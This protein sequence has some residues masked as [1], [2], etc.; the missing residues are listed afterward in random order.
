VCRGLDKIRSVIV[1]YLKD[2]VFIEPT[3][4]T[5]LYSFRMVKSQTITKQLTKFNKIL[6]DLVNIEVII[7]VKDKTLLLLSALHKAKLM[8]QE[9]GGGRKRMFV[10][11]RKFTKVGEGECLFPLVQPLKEK[12][13]E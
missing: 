6:D 3:K 4:E 13:R 8:V 2:K 1:L 11:S 9:D 7:E 12:M 5:K 10:S